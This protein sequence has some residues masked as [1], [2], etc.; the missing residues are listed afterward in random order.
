M[1]LDKT[2]WEII[3]ELF[4]WEGNH[5]QGALRMPIREVSK[6]VGQHPNTVRARLIALRK[7]GVVEGSSFDPYPSVVG[8][9]RA[10]WMCWG[11]Q[12]GTAEEVEARLPVGSVSVAVLGPDWLFSH[13]W[14]R[15]D[16][17]AARR[18]EE[19][20][21]AFGARSVE[22]HY[23][24]TNFPPRPGG[25]PRLSP[26]DRRLVVALRRGPTRS[27]AAVAREL[28]VTSRTV[29]RRAQRLIE[30]GAGGMFPRFRIGRV[31][32][33]VVVHYLV[34]EGDAR[35]AASLAA[36]FPD[37]LFGPFGTGINAGCAVP[38]A[39]LEEA[40]RRR[41]EAERLP[42]VGRLSALLCRDTI[43]PASFEERLDEVVAS[44]Q[45]GVDRR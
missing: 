30:T 24:S 32:G 10:G 2:D 26:L 45:S 42:G 4:R 37:R 7:G 28:R 29:E 9:V 17:E 33:G 22:R 34:V 40:E 27:M 43:F 44:S 1:I 5:P 31:E 35:A 21:Q 36:A 13:I 39:S 15:T 41:R 14:E 18:A 6:R 8:L 25:L 11:V 3:R 23:T 19:I 20:A 16:E 38:V 12:P